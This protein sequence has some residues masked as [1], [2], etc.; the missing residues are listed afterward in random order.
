M[1]QA[2]P[3][4]SRD[5]MKIT[6]QQV[7]DVALLARLELSPDEEA[8]FAGDLDQ[9]LTYIELLDELDTAGVE[10]T[11]H[12]VDMDTPYREDRV[13][14]TPDADALVAGAPERDGTFLKV[15]KIIE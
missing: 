5:A 3:P 11:A 6:R 14:N 2:P 9:I 15:P 13:T 7:R 12:V 8:A 1:R 4:A 10:P